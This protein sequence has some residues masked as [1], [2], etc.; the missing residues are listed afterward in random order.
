MT[1]F[2]KSADTEINLYHFYY[3]HGLYSIDYTHRHCK[4][5]L[6]TL[7]FVKSPETVVW[8]YFVAKK[9]SWVM[10]PTKNYYT[11]KI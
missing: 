9:F 3:K 8:K 11:K 1:K 5:W 6:A 7:Y 2:L 10:K 4:Y